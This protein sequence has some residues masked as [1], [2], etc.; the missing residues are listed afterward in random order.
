MKEEECNHK[1]FSPLCNACGLNMLS[2]QKKELR[3]K[4]ESLRK[5]IDPASVNKRGH[6]TNGAH[7]RIKYNNALDDILKLL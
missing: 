5:E 4:I 2:Q 1:P 6:H 7:R 3:D